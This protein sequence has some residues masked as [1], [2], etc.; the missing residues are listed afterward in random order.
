[1]VCAYQLRPSAAECKIRAK[2]IKKHCVFEGQIHQT[3]FLACKCEHAQ[4]QPQ[5]PPQSCHSQPQPQS[6]LKNTRENHISVLRNSMVAIKHS[7]GHISARWCVSQNMRRTRTMDFRAGGKI[8]QEMRKLHIYIY[9]HC[10]AVELQSTPR[11]YQYAIM[12]H[13]CLHG[14]ESYLQPAT[15]SPF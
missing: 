3:S 1:M 2:S 12:L 9:I 8:H 13:L 4:A 14:P 7:F 6:D 11:Q 5:P 10:S 15:W